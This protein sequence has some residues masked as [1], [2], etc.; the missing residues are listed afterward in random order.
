MSHLP[1]PHL[2][3]I[4][5][6]FG[7]HKSATQTRS[8]Y[9]D[10]FVFCHSQSRHQ[11]T[12]L[13]PILSHTESWHTSTAQKLHL[14]LLG[15]GTGSSQRYTD[16][17]TALLQ[18]NEHVWGGLRARASQFVFGY[19][20]SRTVDAVG[21]ERWYLFPREKYLKTNQLDMLVSGC[22][23]KPPLHQCNVTYHGC[24]IFDADVNMLVNPPHTYAY[25]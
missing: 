5:I 25:L 18:Y 12:D 4:H 10:G 13:G 20:L 15:I 17:R 8:Y 22:R 3:T 24:F 14:L 21:F 6:E 2:S 11:V 7:A 9:D 1:L 23:S 16:H 19:A